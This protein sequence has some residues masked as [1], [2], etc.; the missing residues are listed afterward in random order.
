VLRESSTVFNRLL[1]HISRMPVVD[2][3]DHLRGPDRDLEDIYTEPILALTVLYLI[4]NLW[5]A[6]ASDEEIA[7]LQSEDATTDEKWPVFSRLW[8]CS[9]AGTILMSPLISAGCT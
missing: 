3:H 2:C 1:D 9:W 8:C 6:G 4:S 7:L 5:S